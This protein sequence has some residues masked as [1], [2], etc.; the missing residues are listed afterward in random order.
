M[1]TSSLTTRETV[2]R[3]LARSLVCWPTWRFVGVLEVGLESEDVCRLVAHDATLL[4]LAN[5]LLEEVGLHAR[6][7]GGGEKRI[8]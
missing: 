7:S 4:V 2:D 6:R 5:A 3:G 8:M 1:T